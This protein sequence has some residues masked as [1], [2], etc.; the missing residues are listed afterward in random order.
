[1]TRHR[2][3][4]PDPIEKCHIRAKSAPASVLK[5]FFL[6]LHAQLFSPVVQRPL[7]GGGICRHLPENSPIGKP[8]IAVFEELDK[9][10]DSQGQ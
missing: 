4:R 10:C 2:E 5:L 1:M 3:R 8:L 7:S 9:S 6:Y